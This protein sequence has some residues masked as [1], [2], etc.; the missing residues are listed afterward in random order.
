MT[1]PRE[2]VAGGL[3]A[4]GSRA[5]RSA[6][7]AGLR[8]VPEL[9]RARRRAGR[10]G[11][12]PE[13]LRRPRTCARSPASA[14][15]TA[16]PA[17][18]GRPATTPRSSTWP[19][20]CARRATAC[21]LQDVRFPVFRERSRPRLEAG[22][23][24]LPVASLR[25]SARA[26]CARPS[27]ASGSAAG[28]RLR[29]RA[30]PDRGRGARDVHV[31]REGAPRRGRR[32]RAASS[33]PTA[34]RDEPPRGS[35]GR[36]GIGIPAV[37]AGSAACACAGARC[38]SVDTVGGGRDHAQRDRGAPGLAA[39]GRDARRPPRLGPRGPGDQRQRQRRR[40]HARAGRAA[41]RPPRAALRV[42]GRGG[43]RA[44][45]LA[46]LRRLAAPPSGGGSRATST[47][48]WSARPTRSGTSTAAGRGARRAG[49]R[50]EGAASCASSRSG[51]AGAPTTRRSRPPGSRSA[52][53]TRA[54]RSAR[55]RARRARS[56][57]APGDP[58]DPCYH[59]R[60][61]TLGRVDL[62]VMVELGDAAGGAL[63]GAWASLARR[64]GCPGRHAGPA[65]PGC[66]R[67]RRRPRPDRR[68]RGRRGGRG[69]ERP[70]REP[71][72]ATE[73][74]RSGRAPRRS[75]RPGS[76]RC[77]S[78]SASSSS[79][80]STAPGRRPTCRARC[81]PAARRG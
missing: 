25:Y 8:E 14:S 44:L 65:A 37:G 20:A 27:R 10:H 4:F 45:R 81:G 79:C 22:G 53:S 43:A 18:R 36:P 26:A 63:D 31:P 67:R 55:P 33:S 78:R 73:A 52:G 72:P 46:A 50:P 76:C 66:A 13:R 71:A 62:D 59:Q 60:C 58:L 23:R 48:T 80:A 16:T 56:A 24:R 41:A 68:D 35:L 77:A 64:C 42:L 29:R 32:A 34:K 49:R 28:R 47:S 12:A 40:G 9:R 2:P 54:R 70:P 39:P 69:D 17:P 30:R 7:S 57:A 5:W 6:P 3:G 15:A 19:A 1:V 74:R 11:L 61:D 38:S 21:G 51:S 75:G